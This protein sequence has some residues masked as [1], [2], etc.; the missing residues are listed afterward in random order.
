MISDSAVRH[1]TALILLMAVQLACAVF[2]VTDAV[3]DFF[4]SGPGSL[5]GHLII[6]ALATLSLLVAIALEGRILAS[7]RRRE[8]DLEESLTNA[9]AEV[10]A[11]IMAQFDAWSLSPAERDIAMFL[12]KGLTTQEIAE[13]RG[14]AEGTVKAHFNAIFRKAGVHSRVELLSLLIDRLLGSRLDTSDS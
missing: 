12:V 14:S 13:M 3:Q 4:E 5:D 1:P 6:E 10:H 2:F 7:L 8:A 9:S 11:V